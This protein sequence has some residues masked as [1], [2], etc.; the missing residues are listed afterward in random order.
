[1][2]ALPG[3]PDSSVESKRPASRSLA[4]LVFD[5][6]SAGA[7]PAQAAG[8]ISGSGGLGDGQGG[9]GDSRPALRG[10]AESERALPEK[11]GVLV[12]VPRTHLL[13][14]HGVL[15]LQRGWGADRAACVG[16]HRGR[17]ADRILDG[18]FCG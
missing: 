2:Q 9:G 15:A 16:E 6:A 4:V 18:L 7:L 12:P 5:G 14:Y 1:M 3:A 13:C 17:G 10:R 8:C 11:L